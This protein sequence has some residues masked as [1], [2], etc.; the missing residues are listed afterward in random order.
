MKH[1]SQVI[2]FEITILEKKKKCNEQIT[3]SRNKRLTNYVFCVSLH[4]VQSNHLKN[5]CN[6]NLKNVWIHLNVIGKKT[7][8]KLNKRISKASTEADILFLLKRQILV[9]KWL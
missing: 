6:N 5:L 1:S 3:L 2:Y 7:A 4:T 9:Y 8:Q